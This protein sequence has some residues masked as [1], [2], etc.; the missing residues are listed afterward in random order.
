MRPT[1]FRSSTR[2]RLGGPL[3]SFFG[4]AVAIVTSVALVG[5]N[6]AHAA[7]LAGWDFQTTTNGG[8]AVAGSPATPKRYVS[9]F[10]SGSLY[11]DGSNGSSDWFV[12]ATG[13]TNTELNG[14]GGTVTNTAGTDLSPVT[15]S[16]AALAL[17]AGATT[18]PGAFAANGKFAAFTFNMS[19]YQDL[20][21]SYAA[22]RT[23][24]GFTAQIWEYSGDGVSWSWPRPSRRSPHRSRRAAD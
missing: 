5:G 19:G 18:A 6:S 21:V 14:F 12:P 22:Q 1:H 3:M 16:P 13:Q 24:S 23:S 10:G 7:L 9:N 11:L 15:T 8:T 4:K 2:R 17:V 20:V